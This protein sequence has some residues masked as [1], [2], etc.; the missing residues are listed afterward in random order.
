MTKRLFLTIRQDKYSRKIEK[1]EM[2]IVDDGA[3]Q[4]IGQSGTDKSIL[5]NSVLR[6]YEENCSAIL[7]A[8]NSVE[9]CVLPSRSQIGHVFHIY[10]EQPGL[11]IIDEFQNLQGCPS[12]PSSRMFI[13]RLKCF[14]YQLMNR[15]RTLLGG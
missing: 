12:L 10:P 1:V 4:I 14:L 6:Q 7:N 2:K 13:S 8:Q 11:Y 3:I 5:I 15:V 9:D